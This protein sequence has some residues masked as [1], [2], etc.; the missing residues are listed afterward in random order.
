MHAPA[1]DQCAALSTSLFE[2][3][4]FDRRSNARVQAFNDR[5]RADRSVSGGFER[6][7]NIGDILCNGCK[8][9]VVTLLDGMVACYEIVPTCPGTAGCRAIGP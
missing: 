2:F 3:L 8:E 4:A 5:C 9:F 1:T 7:N 6:T